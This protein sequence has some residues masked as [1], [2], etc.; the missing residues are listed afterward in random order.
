MSLQFPDVFKKFQN[1]RLSGF[2]E[3]IN[4]SGVSRKDLKI[5]KPVSTSRPKPGFAYQL[6]PGTSSNFEILQRDFLV[7]AVDAVVVLVIAA[8]ALIRE[9]SV[10]SAALHRRR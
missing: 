3:Q 1:P 8:S 9:S 7:G 10:P 2:P 5:P 4:A 6:A